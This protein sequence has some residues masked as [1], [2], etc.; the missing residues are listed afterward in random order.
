MRDGKKEL[1]FS[2]PVLLFSRNGGETM[3]THRFY[4]AGALFCHKELIGNHLLAEAIRERSGGK[5]QAN[6]PQ[7]EE[8]Q[9]R[10]SPLE[11]RDNDFRL[12]LD[13]S[14]ALFNFD[15][16]ELDSGTVVEF[17]AAR[18][19]QIPCVLFRTDFRSA[20]DQNADGE[21]W[22]LMCSGYPRT[23]VRSFGAME[24]YQ[25]IF[26]NA[27]STE[28]AL[29]SYYAELADGLIEDF[30]TLLALPSPFASEVEALK[31]YRYF[32][33]VCGGTLPETVSETTLREIIARRG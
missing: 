21:A 10:P 6:L 7:K 20:G 13:S 8:N 25:R 28:E 3:T 15:G 14:L 1:L 22:N 24:P 17:M 11:I 9:L 19:L 30:D 4:F 5:Y 2:R 23:R 27:A 29:R 31:V 18:F 32:L 12:L 33:T 16:T 26:R